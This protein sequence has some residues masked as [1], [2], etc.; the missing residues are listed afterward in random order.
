MQMLKLNWTRVKM[1]LKKLVLK[2]TSEKDIKYIYI[3]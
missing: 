2:I 1:M 3:L